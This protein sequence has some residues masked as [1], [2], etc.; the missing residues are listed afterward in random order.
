MKTKLLYSSLISLLFIIQACKRTEPDCGDLS[1]V[2]TNYNIPDSNKAKIPYIGKDTLVFISDA[3]D[4]A[5]LIGQGKNTH[6][7]SV[8]SN[9]SGGDCPRSSVMNYQNIEINFQS[10]NDTNLS[11]IFL[12]LNRPINAVNYTYLKL[13]L[14]TKGLSSFPLELLKNYD[15]SVLINKE[16]IK[17]Y[18]FDSNKNQVLYNYQKGIIKLIDFKNKIWLIK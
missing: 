12:K 18:Y 2:I 9:I 3:G 15:D 8:R 11:T 10:I 4:T 6:Y 16:Y 5:T 1:D 7:E 17:G 13:F 14:N